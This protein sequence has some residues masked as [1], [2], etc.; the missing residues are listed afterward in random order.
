M[1]QPYAGH[2]LTSA[3]IGSQFTVDGNLYTITGLQDDF[4]YIKESYMSTV[5]LVGSPQRYLYTPK[6]RPAHY[7][8]GSGTSRLVFRY[9]VQRGDNSRYLDIHSFCI[10]LVHSIT[11]HSITSHP[12]NPPS[13]TIL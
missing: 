8:S 4:L 1:N 13:Q 12:P 7:H 10:T 5:V 3:D 9:S 2:D 11:S 6:V